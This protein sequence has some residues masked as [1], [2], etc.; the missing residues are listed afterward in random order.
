VRPVY[1]AFGKLVAE[2]A[3]QAPSNP[4]VNFLTNDN[5]GS[6]RIVTDQNGHAVARHDYMPFGEE[7]S[8]SQRNQNIGYQPDS[9]RKH[10]PV[11]KKTQKRISTLLKPG[12]TQIA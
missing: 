6:P 9:T 8:T 1:D 7:I 12:I 5:L 11:T 4:Q 3:N 10:L 2:Y